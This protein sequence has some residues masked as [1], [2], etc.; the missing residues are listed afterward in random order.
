MCRFR[1]PVDLPGT[2]SCRP[3]QESERPAENGPADR[4]A[5]GRRATMGR[6]RK[7]AF[8][9]IELLVVIAVIA[10]IAAILFPVFAAA[11]DKARQVACFSNLKQIGYALHMY[12]QDYDERLPIACAH[13]RANGPPDVLA[14]E[15]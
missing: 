7:G 9:L 2:A 12:L 10:I 1:E 8:T 15:C 6:V 14:K 4:H 13:G 3:G 11:R 5:P